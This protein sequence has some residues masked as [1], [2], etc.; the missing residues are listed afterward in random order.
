MK[1]LVVDL[2]PIV[3]TQYRR[4]TFH[5]YAD[6]AALPTAGARQHAAPMKMKAF[7]TLPVRAYAV[8]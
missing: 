6:L 7:G 5:R 1:R 4:G 8:V 2:P 3:R